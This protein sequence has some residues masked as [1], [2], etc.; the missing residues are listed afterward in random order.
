MTLYC[1]TSLW[2][3]LAGISSSRCNA[4]SSWETVSAAVRS[5]NSLTFIHSVS[6]QAQS[7]LHP[8]HPS[9]TVTPAQMGWERL[10]TFHLV[11]DCSSLVL[12]FLSFLP[13]GPVAQSV[14]SF[15][16]PEN[17]LACSSCY[18]HILPVCVCVHILKCDLAVGINDFK[19]LTCSKPWHRNCHIRAASV[20]GIR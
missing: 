7:L 8:F 6:Q 2:R 15:S 3:C 19:A 11:H 14:L 13:P 20:S 4:R 16:L 18:V 12:C 17:I 10:L 1:G 9:N 5:L